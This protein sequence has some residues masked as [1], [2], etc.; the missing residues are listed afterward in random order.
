MLINIKNFKKNVK[1]NHELKVNDVNK[2]KK[3]KMTKIKKKFKNAEFKDDLNIYNNDEK[4]K[5]KKFNKKLLN[6]KRFYSD[7]A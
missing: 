4:K 3:N 7:N 2:K 1:F 5:E 6:V